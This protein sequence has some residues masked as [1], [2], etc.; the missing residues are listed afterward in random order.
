MAT[1]RKMFLLIN[2]AEYELAETFEKETDSNV[3]SIR[4]QVDRLVRNPGTGAASSVRM[5]SAGMGSAKQHFQ[6]RTQRGVGELL[7]NP[8]LVVSAALVLGGEP[9]GAPVPVRAKSNSGERP[10]SE[11]G[12]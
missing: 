8:D 9:T 1:N 10:L 2:G 4:K 5:V 11:V 12:F 7:V 6:I 3:D